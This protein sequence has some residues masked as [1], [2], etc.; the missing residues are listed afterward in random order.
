MVGF[1]SSLFVVQGMAH[2][3]LL[4][5]PRFKACCEKGLQGA[6]ELAGKVSGFTAEHLLSMYQAACDTST[7]A[8]TDEIAEDEG[9]E[10]AEGATEDNE[11]ANLL[12]HLADEA[13]SIKQNGLQDE[14][15]QHQESTDPEDVEWKTMPD[16]EEF[17]AM[18]APDSSNSID[19]GGLPATLLDAINRPGDFFNSI[20]RLVVRLRSIRG[21]SDHYWIPNA[22]NSRKAARSLNW[23]QH[24]GLPDVERGFSVEPVWS[25]YLSVNTYPWDELFVEIFCR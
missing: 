9:L 3:I 20:F 21:A 1:Q 23:H 17:Q 8:S 11:C 10:E 19:A 24:L 2:C 14:A 6:L 13:A 25:G 7:F 22:L 4:K 16:K 12:Q 18:L 5:W 15:E